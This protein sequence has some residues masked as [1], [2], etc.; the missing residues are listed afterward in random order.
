MDPKDA[1]R[2]LGLEPKEI[3]V[4]LALLELGEATILQISNKANVKR[5]TAYLV[6]GVLEEKGLVSRV[7]KGR[8]TLYSP[9]HPQKLITEAELRLKELTEIMPQLESVF[10]KKGGKARVMIYEGKEQLDRAYDEM[11]VTKGEVM[12]MSTITLSFE[13]FP[14]TFK[15]IEY[16]IW[17]PDFR[18]RELVDE[19]EEGRKYAERVRG[20]YRQVKFIPKEML[21]FDIDIGIF[22]NKVLITQAKKEYFTVVIESDEISRAFRTIFEVMWKATKE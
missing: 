3:A 10:H 8:K 13:A 17:G 21:P 16:V 11:F 9:Q 20:P 14:R 12:Y 1:L 18:A 22:G 7:L 15:K 19:S 6:L 4:Y 5:P 2:D